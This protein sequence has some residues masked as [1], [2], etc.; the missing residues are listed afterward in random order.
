MCIHACC[1]LLASP[2][3]PK[4][5]FLS[6]AR[7]RANGSA[8]GGCV[9]IPFTDAATFSSTAKRLCFMSVS[10]FP[11]QNVAL[12]M[13]LQLESK[14]GDR[15]VRVQRALLRCDGCQAICKSASKLFCPK[16]GH[17]TLSRVSVT[18]GPDGVEQFG[19]RRKT[20]LRGTRF[21]LMTCIVAILWK[22]FSFLRSRI[23]ESFEA[24]F[25]AVVCLKQQQMLLS[26]IGTGLQPAQRS[27]YRPSCPSTPS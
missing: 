22:T 6:V 15:I 12:Q 20:I 27:E 21:A 16:C 2:F 1:P 19:V 23:M 14:G 5:Y 18:V 24:L 3:L 13:G 7:Q 11:V 8:F 10:H 17:P 9:A 25:G 26:A 4:L